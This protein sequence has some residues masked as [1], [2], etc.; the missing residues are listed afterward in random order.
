M[1]HEPNCLG[2]WLPVLHVPSCTVTT[3]RSRTSLNPLSRIFHYSNWYKSCECPHRL[4]TFISIE[5]YPVIQTNV[6]CCIRLLLKL[7]FQRP[8]RQIAMFMKCIQLILNCVFLIS[9]DINQLYFS[10]ESKNYQK[11]EL[12]CTRL[13]FVLGFRCHPYIYASIAQ[14]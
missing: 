14:R 10:L 8:S 3:N 9:I 2:I 13:S 4:S 12:K 1:H 11:Q 7:G 5:I 6:Q